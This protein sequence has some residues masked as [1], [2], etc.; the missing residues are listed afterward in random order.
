MDE[1]HS[2]IQQALNTK[3]EILDLS[4]QGLTKLPPEIGQLT[5]LTELDLGDNNITFHYY[6]VEV[7]LETFVI[8]N[9]L[10][11]FTKKLGVIIL[12]SFIACVPRGL[13]KC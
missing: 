2:K 5:N 13:R 10:F 1:V 9:E 3:A 6:I 7:Y 11:C 4:G 12:K 8:I